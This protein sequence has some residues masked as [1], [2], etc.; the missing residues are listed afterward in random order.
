MWRTGADPRCACNDHGKRGWLLLERVD[1]EVDNP[2]R[3]F[4]A[5]VMIC[6]ELLELIDDEQ[7]A[8]GLPAVSH[9]GIGKSR[10]L[11]A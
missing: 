6:E 1:N 9:L 4:L 5:E 10:V 3:F 2:L 7:E 8:R 11:L